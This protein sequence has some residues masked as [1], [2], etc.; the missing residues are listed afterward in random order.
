MKKPDPIFLKRTAHLQP[1]AD[2]K[3]D[4]SFTKLHSRRRPLPGA[5]LDNQSLDQ[6]GH[7]IAKVLPSLI[8]V[9]GMILVVHGLAYIADTYAPDGNT[10][11][12]QVDRQHTRAIL[13]NAGRINALVLG[14]S[15]AGS[16]Q[17]KALGYENGYR[18]ARADGDMFEV[19]HFIRSFAPRLTRMDVVFVPVSYFSFLEENSSSQEVDIRRV[20]MYASLPNWQF[21]PGDLEPFLVGK[22]HT[23]L[24][25]PRLIREDN[26]EGVF[27]AL[28][29]QEPEQKG[30]IEVA[31]GDCSFLSAEEMSASVENRV[32]KYMR[33]NQEMSANHP[34]LAKDVYNVMADTYRYLQ[35]RGVRLIFYTPPYYQEYTEQYM[36]Q[37]P[38][39]VQLMYSSMERMQ[40]ELGVE[41]YDFSKD[42]EFAQNRELFKDS[43]HLN[44]C[45][46]EKFS[47]KLNQVVNNQ[48]VA[49]P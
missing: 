1:P 9:L 24:P 26:W 44:S 45:G 47:Q 35:S 3:E 18:F 33:L 7:Q 42:P 16:V 40:Q 34:D 22:S 28:F 11:F 17:M 37:D 36:A 32:A 25:I 46:A 6:K 31:A 12:L 38:A 4:T 30:F 29:G 43:D 13:A 5:S 23:Y 8:F 21:L 39:T 27:Y 20:H 19:H 14:N 10:R 2:V 49:Q 41:Y 15:H 48:K